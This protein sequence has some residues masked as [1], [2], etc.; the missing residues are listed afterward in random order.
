MPGVR[1]SHATERDCMFTLVDGKR[2]YKA[3]INCLACGKTHVFKTY[4]FRLDTVGSTIV[5]EEIIKR[6]KRLRGNGGFTIGEQIT[7]PPAQ[8]VSTGGEFKRIAVVEHPD[9]KEP[10]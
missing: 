2:P 8:F 10:I 5:S 1:I 3:P 7:K 4:H 6:L 9:L